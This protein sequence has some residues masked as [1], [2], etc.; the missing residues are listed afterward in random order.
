MSV[1]LRIRVPVLHV[2]SQYTL[3]GKV[4]KEMLRGNGLLTGNFSKE[5]LALRDYVR[6]L[7]RIYQCILLYSRC[8]GRFYIGTEEAE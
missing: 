5:K 8:S 3:T 1:I 6:K 7:M 2:K 4:G